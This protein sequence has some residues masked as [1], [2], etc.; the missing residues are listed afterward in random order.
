MRAMDGIAHDQE[1]LRVWK[2]LPQD[3]R[4]FGGAKIHMGSFSI[5]F[6]A[7]LLRK[8]TKIFNRFFYHLKSLRKKAGLFHTGKVDLRMLFEGVIETGCATFS[9]P[10]NKK[11]W[12]SQF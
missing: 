9:R 8:E 1:K 2:K 5:S 4:S 7:L 11:I 12:S 10:E 6:F 3:G